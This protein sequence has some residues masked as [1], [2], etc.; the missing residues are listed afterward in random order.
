MDTINLICRKVRNPKTGKDFV[1][2]SF[3]VCADGKKPVRFNIPLSDGFKFKKFLVKHCGVY[4]KQNCLDN[5][6]VGSSEEEHLF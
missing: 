4:D 5:L 2:F 1:V 3:D 6:I